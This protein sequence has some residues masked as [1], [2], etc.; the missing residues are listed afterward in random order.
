MLSLTYIKTSDVYYTSEM[1]SD[2]THLYL[3]I[4]VLHAVETKS[5]MGENTEVT[6]II[7][8]NDDLKKLVVNLR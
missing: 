5:W 1:R 8:R 4:L 2:F 6:E 7:I 3:K